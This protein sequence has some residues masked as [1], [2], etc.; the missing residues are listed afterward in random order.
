M[1][2]RK[3]IIPENVATRKELINLLNEKM[4]FASD[5]IKENIIEQDGKISVTEELLNAAE[6]LSYRDRN[7]NDQK[8]E[9]GRS[10]P[11]VEYENPVFNAYYFYRYGYAYAYEFSVIYDIMLRSFEAT[12]GNIFGSVSFGCGSMIDAWALAYANAGIFREKRYNKSEELE[13]KYIGIDF[14]E[15]PNLFDSK[16]E[17]MEKAFSKNCPKLN[18]KTDIIDF[19]SDEKTYYNYY[20]VLFFSKI[21][22]ELDNLDELVQVIE[23]QVKKGRFGKRTEYYVC[24]SHSKHD[25]KNNERGTLDK[26][27]RV[28]SAINCNN[29]FEVNAEISPEMVQKYN[30]EKYGDNMPYYKFVGQDAIELKNHDFNR[31]EFFDLDRK[32]KAHDPERQCLEERFD[33][34]FR[35][36]MLNVNSFAFQ[37][38][39]LTRRKNEE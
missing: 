38:I 16:N 4:K 5:C 30:L 24:I 6:R 12:E 32:F 2:G 27:N 33:K 7:H 11:N 36:P 34:V 18:S 8:E 21:L 3:P 9:N 28:I 14:R 13:L 1:A 39:K 20:N 37:I 35:A 25:I 31:F 19:L 10:I 17:A 29:E 26:V 15:W 22:N 23:D